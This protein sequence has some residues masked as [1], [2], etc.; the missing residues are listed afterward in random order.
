MKCIAILGFLVLWNS[1]GAQVVLSANGQ[2]DTYGLISSV[3]APGYNPIEVP[4]C[5]HIDFG[6]HIDEV[7]DEDLNKFVFRFHIHTTPDDDRC[8]N[9][10]RQRNEIKT[11]DKSPDNLLG[12]EDE[13]VHYR[14]KFK[15]PSGFQSSP[16]FTHLH[17]LKSVGGDYSSLPMYSILARKGNPD[18]L[19]LRY[20]EKDDTER[21][22]RTDLA[23]FIDTWLQ[24]DEIIKYGTSGT[25]QIQIQ[26]MSDETILFEY[27]NDNIIN[28]K[29]GGS[30][31]RPKWGIYRSLLNA[32]DLRDESVLFADFSIEE[33]TITATDKHQNTK[34]E[35]II[36]SK[37]FANNL[38][39]NNKWKQAVTIDIYDMN[40][41]VIYNGKI[42]SQ[43]ELIIH[44]SLLKK[45][46][47]VL[48]YSENHFSAS[49]IIFIY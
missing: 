29:P 18:Q 3:L 31:V 37:Y 45:G 9:F 28:W 41:S 12:V 36:T 40:G 49:E 33:I 30:F 25:Y 46:N 1:I 44:T 38:V 20:S 16:N 11:Y 19:E 22:K 7:F 32:Q 24:V 27:A 43:G 6:D 34:E 10:D 13:V 48:R 21:L 14:W 15:L 4:D 5:N 17:Q 26:R 8:I 42:N 2:G 39:L 47:Y 23:P 35:Q